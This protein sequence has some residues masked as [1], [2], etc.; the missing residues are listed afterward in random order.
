M[1]L[2][3]QNNIGLE[4]ACQRRIII[5]VIFEKN[6]NVPTGNKTNSVGL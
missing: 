6:K 1:T 2:T 3:P 4:T 5:I